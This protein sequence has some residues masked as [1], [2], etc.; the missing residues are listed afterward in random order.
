M[1][2]EFDVTR[3]S[4]EILH[5]VLHEHAITCKQLSLAADRD[6]STV[7][8]YLSGEKTIPIEVY[9]AIF[10]LTRDLRIIG[11]VNGNVPVVVS[12]AR[13]ADAA[14]VLTARAAPP[15]RPP[16]NQLLPETCA[17]CR[18]SADAVEYVGKIVADGKF[19]R[20]DLTALRNAQR[21]LV[22][23][24]MNCALTQAWLSDLEAELDSAGTKGG[25][26]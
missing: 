13:P 22:S 16:L 18:S 10:C 15:R 24:Q 3:A 23:A 14:S 8:R 12:L 9:R 6:L 2:D 17:A 4:L 7:S 21:H 25:S 19:D 1:K 5:Q 11:L 26:R 20:S